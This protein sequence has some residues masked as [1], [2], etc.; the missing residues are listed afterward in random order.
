M[1]AYLIFHAKNAYINKKNMHTYLI[2]YAYIYNLTSVNT[3]IKQKNKY[4]CI[5]LLIYFNIRKTPSFNKK[6][7]M[8]AYINMHRITLNMHKMVLLLMVLHRIQ[9]S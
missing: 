9:Q 1:H 5:G 2:K 7:N 4:A 3:I 8:H 6:I